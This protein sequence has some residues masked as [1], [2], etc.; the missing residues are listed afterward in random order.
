MILSSGFRGR[1]KDLPT[2]FFT[3]QFTIIFVI[4]PSPISSGGRCR[5]LL[6]LLLLLLLVLLVLLLVLLLLMMMMTVSRVFETIPR[7][8]HTHPHFHPHIFHSKSGIE[9][10]IRMCAFSCSTII[11]RSFCRSAIL[12]ITHSIR[13]HSV[14]QVSSRGRLGILFELVGVEESR[15]RRGGGKLG[16]MWLC[17]VSYI[18]Y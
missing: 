2:T 12:I 10:E 8:T 14:K 11:P 3:R 18:G 1:K 9:I 13:K 6:L 16:R 7:S 4:R 5:N 15:A 17:S